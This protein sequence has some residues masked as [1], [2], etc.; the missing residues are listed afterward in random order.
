MT[1]QQWLNFVIGIGATIALVGGLVGSFIGLEQ[2]FVA[3]ITAGLV[4]V[5]AFYVY[6]TSQTVKASNKQAE[7]MLNAE[8]NAAAPVIRLATSGTGDISIDWENVGK[9]PALNFQCWIEGEEHA[10][11]RI[12]K[13]VRFH[14]VIAAGESGHDTIYTEIKGYKLGVGYIKARYQSVFRKTYESCLIFS[15]DP[16]PEFKYGEA[17]ED[18]TGEPNSSNAQDSSETQLD[19]IERS[20]RVLNLNATRVG[21]F[22][23][24]IAAIIASVSGM[25]IDWWARGALFC[26]G[27]LMII[28][29]PR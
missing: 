15:S 8:Y 21:I 25:Q 7:I 29:A 17:K 11:L 2:A 28:L 20:V 18:S 27:L 3:G 4:Y 26:L 22:A 12:G 14:T 24:A 9:G 6:L 23:I 5:T 10:E 19:R 16:A 1:K 13:K